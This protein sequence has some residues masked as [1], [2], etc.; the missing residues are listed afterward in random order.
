MNVLLH[1]VYTDTLP[2]DIEESLDTCF[3]QHLLEAA[4]RFELVRLR[5]ICEKQLC[6]TVDVDTVATT[7]TLAERNHAEVSCLIINYYGVLINL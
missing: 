2:E 7:L 3:M 1:F 6:Q 5:R 4:D